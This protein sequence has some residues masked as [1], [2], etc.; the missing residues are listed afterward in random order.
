MQNAWASKMMTI[1]NTLRRVRSTLKFKK[2]LRRS[3]KQ[4]KNTAL[5]EK[6]ITMLANDE[7]LPP[8]HR[9]HALT[10]DWIGFR[11][12]HI[13]PDWLLIYHKSDSGELLLV[14]ARLASHSELGF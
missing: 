4:G 10:G 3:E 14:L 12:C 13:T 8:K 1:E 6:I 7:P 11:E 5:A 2:E 9:D